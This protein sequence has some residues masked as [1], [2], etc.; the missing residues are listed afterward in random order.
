M[1]REAPP[2]NTIYT[3]M[4]AVTLGA[5]FVGCVMLAIELSADYDWTTTAPA[6][7]T[8]PARGSAPLAV[9]IQMGRA[10]PQLHAGAN[11][12]AEPVPIVVTPDT[13]PAPVALPSPVVAAAM[14]PVVPEP[15]PKSVETSQPVSVPLAPQSSGITPSPLKLPGERR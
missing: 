9:G 11:P 2:T 8:V 1:P 12:K 6:P 3:G 10:M 14:P 5:V 7:P 15:G 13:I 4:L